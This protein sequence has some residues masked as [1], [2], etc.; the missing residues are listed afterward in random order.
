[1]RH[2]RFGI[3]RPIAEWLE[4][5][6]VLLIF[7]GSSECA[8]RERPNARR[9]R[10]VGQRHELRPAV[11]CR[12]VRVVV[13]VRCVPAAQGFPFP[14]GGQPAL[15][16]SVRPIGTAPADGLQGGIDDLPVFGG[17]ERA[18]EFQ[19]IVT[20]KVRFSSAFVPAWIGKNIEMV[21]RV[22]D[23][24]G[25]LAVGQCL[26]FVPDGIL[27]GDAGWKRIGIG[28]T[29]ESLIRLAGMVEG[30]SVE[31]QGLI[32][33]PGK[34]N[35]RLLGCEMVGLRRNGT[36]P[37][38]TGL[39]VVMVKR[40]F[41]EFRLAFKNRDDL[42]PGGEHDISRGGKVG[43]CLILNGLCLQRLHLDDQITFLRELV[44]QE[45]RCNQITLALRG[46]QQ[47]ENQ[48][49]EQAV[50]SHGVS[51]EAEH[52]TDRT[53]AHFGSTVEPIIS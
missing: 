46:Q 27:D 25:I 32:R 29:D 21:D 38:L 24:R 11:T 47:D 36:L 51:S 28:G 8:N 45:R 3:C 30:K 16:E 10:R 40:D 15:C 42:Q 1:M 49:G 31:H 6:V 35:V 44:E 20:R 23:V 7:A 53:V 22:H 33:L 37:D 41:P 14:D 48:S 43:K 26:Q 52:W 12:R 34:E 4:E 2:Q 13:R 39:L 18:N 17:Q 19:D 9:R 50:S 5:C